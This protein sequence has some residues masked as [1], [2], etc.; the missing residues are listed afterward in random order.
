MHA[1]L[2]SYLRDNRD[3]I[4]ENW[5]TEVEIP[6]PIESEKA[7]GGVVPYEF[8]TTAFD[9]CWRSSN[10]ALKQRPAPRCST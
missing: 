9:A 10:M 3:Q 2:V 4:I 6:A 7:E 8:F 1:R 5:L